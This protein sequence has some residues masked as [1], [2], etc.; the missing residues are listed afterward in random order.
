MNTG[1]LLGFAENI[2]ME[3]MKIM[4]KLPIPANKELMVW[5][6][7]TD[8]HLRIPVSISRVWS[9]FLDS[10]P[11]IY[12]SGVH[13]IN[14]TRETLDGLQALIDTEENKTR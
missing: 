13:L 1:E 4:S 8:A 6:E 7:K 9:S 12:Y 2:H 11:V 5:L 10:D 14:P 3:G